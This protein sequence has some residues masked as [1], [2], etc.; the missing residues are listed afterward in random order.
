[1]DY[2]PIP[3]VKMLWESVLARPLTT[4]YVIAFAVV[5]AGS[6]GLLESS[7]ALI[8]LT[9]IFMVLLV[10]G[11]HRE[12]RIEARIVKAELDSIRMMLVN[13]ALINEKDKP[14]D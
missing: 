13:S 5:I 11:L 14:H 9:V 3:V 7:H 4:L 2:R 10:L 6:A 8:L 1:M 12:N